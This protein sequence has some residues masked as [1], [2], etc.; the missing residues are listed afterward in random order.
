MT[1]PTSSTP[2]SAGPSTVR[3]VS[4]I[5]RYGERVAL[6]LAWIVLIVLFSIKA[7]DRFPTTNNLGSVL[8]TQSALFIL[9]LAALLPAMVGDLDLSLGFSGALGAMTMAVLNAQ[10][11]WPIVPAALASVAIGASC[12]FV[13]GFLV[14]KLKTEPFIMTLGTGALFNGFLLLVADSNTITGVSSSLADW[15]YG[16]RVWVI[17][18]QFF[19]ALVLM[20]FIWYVA[21]HTP[22]GVRA[23]FVGKSRDVARL[24]GINSDR[25]RWGAFTAAGAIAGFAAVVF[26]GN[27][28][29]MSPTSFSPYL[30]P[31]YAAVFLGATTIHPGRFNPLGTAIAVLFLATGISGLQIIGAQDYAQYM[32]YGGTL[33][34]AVAGSRY[35][36]GR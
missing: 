11:D 22:L 4:L 5:A 31:A 33:I 27:S 20:L 35:L 12:G 19:Y 15:T 26:V 28:L 13:N 14:V 3:Q 18:I 17:P 24:S 9:A 32:F 16:N 25:I 8:G 23:L 7:S 29:S 6:P 21:E 34:V 10:H 1:A 36:R 30:L 2:T